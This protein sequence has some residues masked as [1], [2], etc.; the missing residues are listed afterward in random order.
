MSDTSTRVGGV[1]H[2][3]QPHNKHHYAMNALIDHLSEVKW[4]DKPEVD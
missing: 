3:P 2:Q 4:Q 1:D